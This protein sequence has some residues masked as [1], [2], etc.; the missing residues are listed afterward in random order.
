MDEFLC[1]MLLGQHW[2]KKVAT[3]VVSPHAAA[4]FGA[5]FA[6]AH[7]SEE[8]FSFAEGSGGMYKT[9]QPIPLLFLGEGKG[10]IVEAE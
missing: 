10:K 4:R 2:S 5:V 6:G 7:R 3:F 1:W 8:I 9:L